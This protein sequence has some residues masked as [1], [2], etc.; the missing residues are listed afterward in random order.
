VNIGR[1]GD[2][3]PGDTGAGRPVDHGDGGAGCIRPKGDRIVV[4]MME[5][6]KERGGR[7]SG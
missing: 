3:E 2:D 7:C 1:G 6:R 5:R 4:A